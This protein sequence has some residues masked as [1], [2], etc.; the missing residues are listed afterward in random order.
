MVGSK[1]TYESNNDSQ[2]VTTSHNESVQ[3]KTESQQVKN[4]LQQLTTTH[5]ESKL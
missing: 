1:T 2:R 5:S 4:N 3:V